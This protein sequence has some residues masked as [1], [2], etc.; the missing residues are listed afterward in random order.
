MHTIT[1]TMK[2]IWF[3]LTNSTPYVALMG[4]LWVSFVGY[5][6]K[7]DRDISRLDISVLVWVIAKDPVYGF[8]STSLK[9]NSLGSS[10]LV[11]LK[12]KSIQ[13]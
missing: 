7:N 11:T 4:E 2:K 3:A 10:W 6:K 12:R 9:I 8:M 5:T 1:I 13:L